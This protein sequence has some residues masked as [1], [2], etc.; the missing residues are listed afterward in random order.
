MHLRLLARADLEAV[1]L[2]RNNCREA[3]FDSREIDAG[4]QVAWFERL[5]RASVS[6]FVI[7]E[8]GVVVGTVSV[9][10]RPD[11]R[12][13]GNLTLHPSCRG[14]GL[15]RQAVVQLTALPGCYVAE[16]RPDN[17]RSLR[18]FRAAGFV[19]EPAEDMVIVRKSVNA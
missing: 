19:E 16:I 9:T 11:A 13:V 2:L 8:D 5:D 10:D 7:E 6:F 1:R 15:M 17:A 18:V 4:Q 3:F 12:E 14:R